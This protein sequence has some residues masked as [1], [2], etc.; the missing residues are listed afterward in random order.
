LASSNFTSAS[1]R[2]SV[3]SSSLCFS[4][5]ISC[6]VKLSSVSSPNARPLTPLP[7]WKYQ[8]QP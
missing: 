5:S 3:A 2:A 8:N 7:Q 1:C 4:S 6:S